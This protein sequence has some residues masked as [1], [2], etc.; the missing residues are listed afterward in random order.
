MTHTRCQVG[1]K[2]PTNDPDYSGQWFGSISDYVNWWRSAT[3]KVKIRKVLRC[4]S[5]QRVFVC[6]RLLPLFCIRNCNQDIFGQNNKE[7]ESAAFWALCA[8]D[9]TVKPVRKLSF[10]LTSVVEILVLSPAP[11]NVNDRHVTVNTC[12]NS[13]SQHS[14]I[15]TPCSCCRKIN[16]K[17]M[18]FSHGYITCIIL[19]RVKIEFWVN[20][21]I[22]YSSL[23]R[24][25]KEV[26]VGGSDQHVTEKAAQLTFLC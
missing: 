20:Y 8:I 11:V 12:G 21:I 1:S 4:F 19:C 15:Q 14:R 16:S 3:T 2:T 18:I 23:K 24:H 9:N 13:W 5:Q 6:L 17:R 26:G 22:T 7:N 25:E 10:L